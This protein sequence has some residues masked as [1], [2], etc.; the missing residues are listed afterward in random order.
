[1]RGLA[2]AGF[3]PVLICVLWCGLSA[4]PAIASEA[5]VTDEP[6]F[7]FYGFIKV[8]TVYDLRR[9]DPDWNFTLRPSQIP[10]RADDTPPYRQDGEF[11]MSVRPSRV[12]CDIS[13]PTAEGVVTGKLEIDFVGTGTSAGQHMPRLRHAY[14][15]FGRFLA[16]QTWSLFNDPDAFPLTMDFWGPCGILSSRRPQLRW[17]P[18]RS[19]SSRF[20]LALGTPGAGL[21]AGRGPQ[22]D[23]NFD[24]RFHGRLPDLTAQFRTQG[25]SG[26]LQ[27]AAVVRSLGYE[28]STGAGADYR[29]FDGQETGYG[30]MISTRIRTAGKSGLRALFSFGRGYAN[31]VNDGGVDLA[32]NGEGDAEAVPL[33]TWS[34]FYEAWWSPRW[35]TTLGASEV[36][37]TN[38]AGQELD[39]FK[40]GRYAL[41]NLVYHPTAGLI[42]GLELLWGEHRNKV[43]DNAE[44]VRVQVSARY[45]F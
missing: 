32:R 11:I 9:T 15:Q 2:I 14:G 23:P 24:A 13:L 39:A 28:G 6:S 16:G 40:R 22:V 25:H 19:E 31:Y 36:S 17:T 4:S 45:T 21:D 44:D 10:F 30:G 38:T 1:M 33:V 7:V 29:T 26:Y 20:A 8:D 41:V 12:G 35:S 5:V 27:L 43:D 18:Y 42:Y 3:V 37:Q 34:A